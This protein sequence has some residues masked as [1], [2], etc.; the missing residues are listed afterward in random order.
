MGGEQ[1]NPDRR[2][3]PG[4]NP[5]YAFKQRYTAGRVSKQTGLQP[6]IQDYYTHARP[7][8]KEARILSPFPGLF[9]LFILTHPAG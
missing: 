4:Q 6:I 1:A 3:S 8:C 2:F 9:S 5:D 7:F